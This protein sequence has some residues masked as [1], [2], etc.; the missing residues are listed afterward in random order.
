[1]AANEFAP[2]EPLEKGES[3]RAEEVG[4]PGEHRYYVHQGTRKGGAKGDRVGRSF[5]PM[6]PIQ[7]VARETAQ[8]TGKSHV[9][10]DKETGNPIMEAK[11]DGSEE[12]YYG[13]ADRGD[14]GVRLRRHGDG[15]TE[16]FNPEGDRTD[17]RGRTEE[18]GGR[19]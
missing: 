9:V 1:M 4:A 6:G 11:P 8:R 14:G 17:F 18:Q 13:S 2:V 3:L 19:P 7:G 5:R 15:S 12:Q 10:I 16:Y